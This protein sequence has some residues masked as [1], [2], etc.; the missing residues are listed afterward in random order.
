M[1]LEFRNPFAHSLVKERGFRGVELD[2]AVGL[3]KVGHRHRLARIFECVRCVHDEGDGLVC[4]QR[5]ATVLDPRRTNGCDDDLF[6]VVEPISPDLAGETPDEAHG[7][8][9]RP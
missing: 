5:L 2:V 6:H 8:A 1:A 7:A 9:A 4:E 3:V